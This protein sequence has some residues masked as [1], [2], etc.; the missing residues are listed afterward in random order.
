MIDLQK[1]N[2]ITEIT[3]V[4]IPILCFLAIILTR[5]EK[6]KKRISDISF[7]QSVNFLAKWF[8]QAQIRD[9]V[10]CRYKHT[11]DKQFT[12]SEKFLFA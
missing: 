2:E 1:R 6:K 5:K 9:V 7:L 11:S 8:L 12:A 3:V 10:S 4:E